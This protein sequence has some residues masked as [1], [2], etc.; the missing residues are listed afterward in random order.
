M[1][2]VLERSSVP[3]RRADWDLD[4]LLPASLAGR[5]TTVPLAVRGTSHTERPSNTPPT[6]APLGFE[7]P[8]GQLST[9]TIAPVAAVT[10][11]MLLAENGTSQ[12]YFPSNVPPAKAPPPPE[13]PTGQSANKVMVPFVLVGSSRTKPTA[14]YGM[15]HT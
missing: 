7:K 9:R 15:S 2:G 3:L 5:N 14:V 6:K 8:S 11:T 12:M 4:S 1:V 10:R 13:K